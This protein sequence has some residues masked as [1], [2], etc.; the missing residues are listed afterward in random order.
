MSGFE[1]WLVAHVVWVTA[2]A[3]AVGLVTRFVRRPEI[4]HALWLLV[5]LRM[6][7]PPIFSLPVLPGEPATRTPTQP[8]TPA[9]P[10][11]TG[12]DLAGAMLALHPG[13]GRD[14]DRVPAAGDDLFA[15][16]VRPLERVSVPQ[17]P[18]ARNA[19]L[20]VL[21]CGAVAVLAVAS[22]R[23]LRFR[24][25]LRIARPAGRRLHTSVRRLAGAIGVRRVP[26]VRLVPARVPPMLWA[27]FGAPRLLVPDA[28][29]ARL[30]PGGRDALLLHELAHV[31]RR[32]HWVRYLELAATAL[33][34][35]NPVLWWARRRLRQAEEECCDAWVVRVLP[36]SARAY[37]DAILATVRFVSRS[38]SALPPAASGLDLFRTLERRLTMI[39]RPDRSRRLAAP[40]RF[41][42]LVCAAAVLA[43]LPTRSGADA[44][45][46]PAPA[47]FAAELLATLEDG[48]AAK[49]DEPHV[50]EAV[51]EALRILRREGHDEAVRALER[52]LAEIRAKHEE[53]RSRDRLAQDEQ[54]HR[55]RAEEQAARARE[56]ASQRAEHEARAAEERA[57]AAAARL[58]DEAARREAE[59]AARERRALLDRLRVELETLRRHVDELERGRS[60]AAHAQIRELRDELD[61]SRQMH[62]QQQAEFEALRRMLLEKRERS[63]SESRTD[64]RS[65]YLRDSDVEAVLRALE[66]YSTGYRV[67]GPGGSGAPSGV[68]RSRKTAELHAQRS[69]VEIDVQDTRS[70]IARLEERC[71]VL[72]AEG[73]VA[74]LNEAQAALGT[75]AARLNELSARIAAI[76]AQLRRL[77]GDLRGAR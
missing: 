4:V 67:R 37:A 7:V 61:R 55:L 39:L 40:A 49:A 41:A 58:A 42:L 26:A 48:A 9:T 6:V 71:A 31:R 20:V 44:P 47:E 65:T 77:V 13:V 70:R 21:A 15:M 22:W 33:F 36:G 59:V 76:D 24:R 56:Q 3:V 34:W 69:R 64:S 29:L 75:E 18:G 17:A 46:E 43:V 32:D 14:P 27:L 50:R 73:D 12:T 23:T 57:R 10:D 5:L 54:L 16:A 11:L 51:S 19:A 35:W 74:A 60:G 2:L 72:K 1:G 45:D 68:E 63:G 38:P 8:E 30:E 66:E 28:L 52:V 53:H 25:M 62:R